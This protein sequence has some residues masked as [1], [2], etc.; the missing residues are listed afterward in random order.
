MG[1]KSK[2]I[3]SV[4]KIDSSLIKKVEEFIRKEENR[5][6]FN[7]KK[8]FIDLAVYEFLKNIDNPPNKV[9]MGRGFSIYP[10]PTKCGKIKGVRYIEENSRKK[11]S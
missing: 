3:S 10:T 9:T 1:N 4:V 7:N 5:L 11:W 8:Q 6:R 2:E